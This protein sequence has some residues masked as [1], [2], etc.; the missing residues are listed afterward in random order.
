MVGTVKQKIFVKSIPPGLT[1]TVTDLIL[2]PPNPPKEWRANLVDRSGNDVRAPF[3]V[4][5][6]VDDGYIGEVVMYGAHPFPSPGARLKIRFRLEG[7][8]STHVAGIGAPEANA[9]QTPQG[10]V[11]EVTSIPKNSIGSDED[12]A[13]DIKK[14][15]DLPFTK[16]MFQPTDPSDIGDSKICRLI[17]ETTDWGLI[18]R[19]DYVYVWYQVHNET[20]QRMF[21]K[22]SSAILDMPPPALIV[23]AA[24]ERENKL[25]ISGTYA[26]DVA[27]QLASYAVKGIFWAHEKA[28][29]WV[30]GK[31]NP[32]QFFRLLK[33]R[34]FC[35]YKST[36]SC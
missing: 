11:G 5:T 14:D 21:Y 31:L 33:F 4:Q 1:M 17:V 29:N 7:T 28:F 32:F 6:S 15:M 20:P 24:N 18:E 2:L 12:A 25:G 36:L 3:V 22:L 30:F 16:G 13:P 26:S 19:P 27:N 10:N 8:P 23:I 34:P 9:D 35:S